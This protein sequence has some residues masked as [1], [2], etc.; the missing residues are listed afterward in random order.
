MA[1][2]G[3]TMSKANET[4]EGLTSGRKWG[5]FPAEDNMMEWSIERDGELVQG[6]LDLEFLRGK[7]ILLT[8]EPNQFALLVS[9]NKLQ[10]V[11]LEGGHQMEIGNGRNQIPTSSSLVFLA[12]NQTIQQRW[13]KLN[14]V[15]WNNQH[16]LESIGHCTLHIDAPAR[17]YRSFLEKTTCWDEQSINQAIAEVNREALA[18]ILE[19]SFPL[20]NLDAAL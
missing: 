14:P 16:G 1:E 3:I 9:D 2:K 11:Y 4:R 19:S 6:P 8:L 13:T 20:S 18:T 15:K 10:A 5:A 17:F 12:A 7:R